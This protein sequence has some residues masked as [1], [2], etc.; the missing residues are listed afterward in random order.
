MKSQ[1]ICVRSAFAAVLLHVS[2]EYIKLTSSERWQ[3]DN[4]SLSPCGNY[5]SVYIRTHDYINYCSTPPPCS[6]EGF[7][8]ALCTETLLHSCA[9]VSHTLPVL[10]VTAL[11]GRISEGAT[12]RLLSDVLSFSSHRGSAE[13]SHHLYDVPFLAF[14]LLSVPGVIVP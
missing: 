8:S 10:A 5:I 2:R 14:T 7:R 11:A 3:I 1:S 4:F 13:S 6:A 9:K 12:T